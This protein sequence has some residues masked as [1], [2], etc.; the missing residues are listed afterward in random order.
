MWS[1]RKPVKSD[2]S[3]NS[4]VGPS[5]EAVWGHL[6]QLKAAVTVLEPCPP[7]DQLLPVAVPLGQKPPGLQTGVTLVTK[8]GSL[9][10][11]AAPPD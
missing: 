8:Q 11:S 2:M 5:P 9:P 4:A 10:H 3:E 1:E 6:A 7:G